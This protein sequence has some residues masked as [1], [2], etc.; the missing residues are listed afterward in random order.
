MIRSHTLSQLI[1]QAIASHQI[2]FVKLV[3][4]I[5][6]HHSKW[7]CWFSPAPCIIFI[8]QCSMFVVSYTVHRTPNE[9]CVYVQQW[10]PLSRVWK[11]PIFLRILVQCMNFSASCYPFNEIRIRFFRVCFCARVECVLNSKH[12]ANPFNRTEHVPDSPCWPSCLIYKC[13]LPNNVNQQSNFRIILQRAA[14]NPF[15][16]YRVYVFNGLFSTNNIVLSRHF[17]GG[18]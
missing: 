6:L 2:D 15:L 10:Y 7:L 3:Q 4:H 13:V 16:W 8:S 5:I 1:F 18:V 11:N 14:V 9:Q 17:M 12:K